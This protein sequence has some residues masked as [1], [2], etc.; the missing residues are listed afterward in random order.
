MNKF[1]QFAN[2]ITKGMEEHR[3]GLLAASAVL[4]LIASNYLFYKAGPKAERVLEYRKKELEK[5]LPKEAVKELN[6]QTLKDLSKIFAP[7]VLTSAVSGVSTLGCLTTSNKKIAVLKT[8]VDLSES[9]VKDLN[10]KMNEVLGE[11]KAREVK[12][13]IK[14]DKLREKPVDREHPIM[15]PN[16]EMLVKDVGFSNQQFVSSVPKIEAIILNLSDRVRNEMFVPLNDFLSAA[17]GEPVKYGDVLGWNAED[18][19]YGKVPIQ[20]TATIDD[21]NQVCLLVDYDIFS[22][23]SSYGD[24]EKF[25]S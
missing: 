20:V 3:S 21:S 16:G 24:S 12:D 17:G 5:D 1:T 22:R 4:S 7:A 6:K 19:L 14:K 9:A 23:K 15:I 8:A 25:P 2:K 11:K 10:L 13:A 18:T